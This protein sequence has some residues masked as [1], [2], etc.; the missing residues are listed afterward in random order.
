MNRPGAG[1]AVLLRVVVL[2]KPRQGPRLD[3]EPVRRPQSTR[4]RSWVANALSYP[5]PST[6]AVTSVMRSNRKIDTKPE[7]NLRSELHRRG[8]RFRKHSVPAIEGRRIVV[9]IVFPRSRLAVFVD[10]CFWHSCPDHGTMPT[11]NSWYWGPKL[12]RNVERD[13]DVS[14]R[15]RSAGWRVLRVWE[16]RSVWEAADMVEDAL[17]SS[18]PNSADGDLNPVTAKLARRPAM[19]GRLGASRRLARGH[20]EER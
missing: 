8:L 5:Q 12:R 10:G 19:V 3:A 6:V 14:A 9:D 17:A 1:R 16:H 7:V 4:Y 13:H 11:A 2:E 20:S 15:L 18:R